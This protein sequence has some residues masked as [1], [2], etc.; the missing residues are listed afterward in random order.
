MK[1][2]YLLIPEGLTFDQLTEA[3]Q[4]AINGIFGQYVMPIPGSH[5]VDGTVICNA[6][7]ADS[8]DPSAMGALGLDWEIIGMW[9]WNGAADTA[10]VLIPLDEDAY[11]A[12]LDDIPVLDDEGNQTGTQPATLREV[13][14]WSGWP[15]LF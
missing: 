9:Q 12:R 11:L 7:C 10:T 3:Q 4:A 14:R 5:A 1:T 15:E 6:V 2:V 8:F 13:N